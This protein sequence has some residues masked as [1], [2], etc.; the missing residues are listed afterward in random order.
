[1]LFVGS[2]LRFH[3]RGGG[4]RKVPL[5]AET[6]AL[7]REDL[8]EHPHA[9]N[10]KVRTSRTHRRQSPWCGGHAQVRKPPSWHG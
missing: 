10:P 5:T 7:L 8:V 9:D 3:C 2:P 4:G 1:M 6:T